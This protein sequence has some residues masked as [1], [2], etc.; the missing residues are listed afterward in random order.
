MAF[1]NR[2]IDDTSF[3]EYVAYSGRLFGEQ[4]AGFALAPAPGDDLVT[5]HL[6]GLA[7]D[8]LVDGRRT[9]GQRHERT[10]ARD[11]LEYA[12]GKYFLA[13]AG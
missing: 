1:E 12:R 5:F 7:E 8:L 2:D 3:P 11:L 6:H 10:V 13:D 4:P 9:L